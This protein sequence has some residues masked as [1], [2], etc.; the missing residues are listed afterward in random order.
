MSHVGQIKNGCHE[1]EPPA[2]RPNQQ[3]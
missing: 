2:M 3:A 1:L